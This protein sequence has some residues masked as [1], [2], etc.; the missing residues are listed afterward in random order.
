MFKTM[1]A[2][3]SDP[4]RIDF[5]KK[6]YIV[7]PK[8]DGMRCYITSEGMFS[9]N[10][11]PVV[12]APHIFEELKPFFEEYGDGVILDGELYNHE[13][14]DNFSKIISLVRKTKPTDA[15]LLESAEK[16]QFHCYDMYP[17][18]DPGMS[19]TDREAFRVRN[20][21]RKY[22]SIVHVGSGPVRSHDE[23]ATQEQLCLDDGYEG[24]MIR[25][26]APYELKRSWTLQKVKR[27]VDEEFKIVGYEERMKRTHAGVKLENPIPQGM[28]G[29]FIMEMPDGR[30]FGAPPGKGYDHVDLQTMWETRDWFV[31]SMA[32]V[33]FFEYTEYGVPRFPKYKSLRNYE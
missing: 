7:Q 23:V 8:L 28:L 9:R 19:F 33:E 30:T 1:L 24:A 31:G 15:D 20:I 6:D 11:K 29:K 21:S 14:K 2:H 12:S 32:T 26:D 13:L 10:N 25:E 5:E 17:V 18:Y 4:S 22:E 3:K 16:V 27:F